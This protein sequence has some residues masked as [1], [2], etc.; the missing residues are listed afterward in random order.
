MPLP[1]SKEELQEA[2]HKIKTDP[3]WG[4]LWEHLL[5]ARQECL[6]R[7]VACENWEAFLALRGEFNALNIFIE[8]GDKLLDRLEEAQLR[9]KDDTRRQGREGGYHGR[10][11]REG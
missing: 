2:L 6:F 9:E 5:E 7:M 1:S 10:D 11:D 8:F 4:L 3:E